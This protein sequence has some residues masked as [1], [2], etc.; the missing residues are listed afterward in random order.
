[1]MQKIM[2]TQSPFFRKRLIRESVSSFQQPVPCP[3]FTSILA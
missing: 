1:M 3:P 2:I